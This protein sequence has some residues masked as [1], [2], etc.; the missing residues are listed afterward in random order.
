MFSKFD[1]LK[2]VTT[3][4]ACLSDWGTKFMREAENLKGLRTYKF[5]GQKFKIASTDRLGVKEQAH[6]NSSQIPKFV[7]FAN[8]A[9]DLS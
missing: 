5:S 8:T 9:F 3:I 6:V 2:S 1:S 7:L 4:V